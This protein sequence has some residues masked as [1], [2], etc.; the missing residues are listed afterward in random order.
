[1]EVGTWLFSF[2]NILGRILNTCYP[3]FDPI[4]HLICHLSYLYA[5]LPPSLLNLFTLLFPFVPLSFIYL[6]LPSFHFLS[7]FWPHIVVLTQFLSSLFSHIWPKNNIWSKIIVIKIFGPT[8]TK[9]T[10]I[11]SMFWSIK[12]C[13]SFLLIR[14]F[15]LQLFSI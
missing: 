10:M 5:F 11:F 15:L 1:M 6:L 7:L 13:Q 8:K 3:F 2:I 9:G 4:L 14:K 12:S